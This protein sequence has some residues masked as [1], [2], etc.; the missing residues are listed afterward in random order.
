MIVVICTQA[1]TILHILK[2]FIVYTRANRKADRGELII[3]G[4]DGFRQTL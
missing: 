1:I 4:Q 3:E 2:N